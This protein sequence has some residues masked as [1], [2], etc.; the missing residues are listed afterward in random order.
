MKFWGL[1]ISQ[2]EPLYTL[3]KRP[4]PF[5]TKAS[6]HGALLFQRVGKRASHSSA[7]S[8]LHCTKA[9]ALGNAQRSKQAFVWKGRLKFRSSKV[10]RSAL[11]QSPHSRNW[12]C[13]IWSLHQTNWQAQ[14][15]FIPID[16]YVENTERICNAICVEDEARI[17]EFHAFH[18]IFWAARLTE[19]RHTS[20]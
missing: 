8:F 7:L 18:S 1:L 16:F 15:H 20:P 19:E 9:R 5:H 17:H 10:V 6:N 3:M 11:V 13:K 12:S 4:R 2:K 14:L